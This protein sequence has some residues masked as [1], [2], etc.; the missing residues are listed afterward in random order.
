MHLAECALRN[1][2]GEGCA[3]VWNSIRFAAGAMYLVTVF[4]F[5]DDGWF[6]P[7]ILGPFSAEDFVHWHCAMGYFPDFP[8]QKFSEPLS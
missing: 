5:A 3:I 2:K 4:W 6:D 7:S 8:A 1:R